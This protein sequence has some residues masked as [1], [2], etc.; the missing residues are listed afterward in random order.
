[1]VAFFLAGIRRFGIA[2]IAVL[3]KTITTDEN[4]WYFVPERNAQCHSAGGFWRGGCRLGWKRTGAR[5]LLARMRLR[6]DLRALRALRKDRRD[7][8]VTGKGFEG[9]AVRALP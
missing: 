4:S 2:C 8:V 7:Q 9:C 3:A 1:V 6:L 5:L